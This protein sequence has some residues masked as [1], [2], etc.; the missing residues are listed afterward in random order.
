MSGSEAHHKSTIDT[1]SPR[2][3]M[4]VLTLLRYCYLYNTEYL[5]STLARQTIGMVVSQSIKLRGK[6]SVW[7]DDRTESAI[8]VTQN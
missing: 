1:P 3:T 7:K 2:R 6:T 8:T 5:N 4:T